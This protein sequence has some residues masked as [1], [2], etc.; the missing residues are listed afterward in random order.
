[1]VGIFIVQIVLLGHVGLVIT[2]GVRGERHRDTSKNIRV[3]DIQ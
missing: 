3:P 1:M 2:G